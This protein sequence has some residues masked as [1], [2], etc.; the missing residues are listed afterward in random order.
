MD[1][2]RSIGILSVGVV[3]LSPLARQA[4]ADPPPGH[5]YQQVWSDTFSGNSLDT[6]KWDYGYPASF[7][8]NG[9]FSAGQSGYAAMEPSQV[10]VNNG[11]LDLQA[12]N[13]TDPNLGNYLVPD[14]QNPGQYVPL[15]WRGGYYDNTFQ[16]WVPES[17]IAYESGAINTANKQRWHYGY[18]EGTFEIPWQNSAWPAFWMLQ[19][20]WPPEVDIFEF[21][22][23]HT[24]ENYTYHYSTGSGNASW[25]GTGYPGDAHASFHTYAVEWLPGVLNYYIDGNLIASDTDKNA[26]SQMNNMYLLLDMQVGGWAP[27]PQPGEYG[28]NWGADYLCSGIHVW[29]MTGPPS[30]RYRLTPQ[31]H[32]DMSLDV[33]GYVQNT[34]SGYPRADVWWAGFGENQKWYVQQQD[35]GSYTLQAYPDWSWDHLYLD[36]FDGNNTNGNIV[37]LWNPTGQSPQRWYFENVGGGWYRLIPASAP[38]QTLDIAGGNGAQAGA[39]MDLWPYWGGAGQLFRLDP[40]DGPPALSYSNITVSGVTTT[41]AT[42]SWT[43]YNL[44]NSVVN[45]GTTSGY[46]S[47]ASSNSGN[48][49][50]HSVTLSNLTSGTTY[51]YQI[52]GTDNFSQNATSQDASFTTASTLGARLAVTQV[53]CQRNAGQEIVTLQLTDTGASNATGVQLNSAKL[54]TGVATDALPLSIGTIAALSSQTL[55]LHFPAPATTS[56]L[57]SWSGMSS[58]GAFNGMAL[59]KTP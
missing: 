10:K 58:A 8:N 26:I 49:M 42:I 45:Y 51:H 15:S 56:T 22:G 6:S 41:S 50:T 1:I 5:G 13:Q 59:A 48:V 30:G 37:G 19:D 14:S 4:A 25:G 27:D 47:T 31:L 43:S 38:G 40:P 24:Q 46:G 52:N 12:I 44:A 55:T 35:D 3:I 9:Y 36:N 53:S 20:G 2:R 39:L 11:I 54:G 57:L 16:K 17:S 21:H 23:S 7:G 34:N 28:S 18:F 33:A 29:Q 32:P